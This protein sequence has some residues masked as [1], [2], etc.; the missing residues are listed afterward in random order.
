MNITGKFSHI[1]FHSRYSCGRKETISEKVGNHG[2][3]NGE[4]ASASA[5]RGHGL[6]K[7]AKRDIHFMERK[8][9]GG[10]GLRLVLDPV[11][12]VAA[13]RR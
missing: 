2:T 7:V 11:Q 13:H 3:V 4:R 9:K 12:T 8:E 10:G 1:V 5:A 6:V